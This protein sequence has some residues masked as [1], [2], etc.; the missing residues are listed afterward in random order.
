MRMKVIGAREAHGESKKT[1]KPYDITFVTAIHAD[2]QPGSRG[3]A[4]ESI[5]LDAGQYPAASIELDVDY[6]IDFDP[7]GRCVGFSPCSKRNQ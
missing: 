6:N 1:G 5:M 2:P 7:R 4:A 3:C